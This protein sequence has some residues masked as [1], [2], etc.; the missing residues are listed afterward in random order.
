MHNAH[1]EM[2]Q[3]MMRQLPDFDHA[4]LE[5][6]K[7]A[8]QLTRHFRD[9]IDEP[10]ATIHE[11]L[12]SGKLGR[13]PQ[14]VEEALWSLSTGVYTPCERGWWKRWFKYDRKHHYRIIPPAFVGSIR[15]DETTTYRAVTRLFDYHWGAKKRG[16]EMPT[17]VAIATLLRRSV[18]AW[19]ELTD[20]L[21][22]MR[23]REKYR[24]ERRIVRE[25]MD[26]VEEKGL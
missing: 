1:A 5:A 26:S 9:V 16:K 21:T 14:L 8:L 4:H 12:E 22:K 11:L 3:G 10:L 19:G 13:H 17:L 18:A 7:N 2:L 20:A 23:N 24:Q 6:I 25:A 15:A